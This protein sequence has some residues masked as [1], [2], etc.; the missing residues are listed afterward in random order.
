[1]QTIHLGSKGT[2][3]ATC[4]DASALSTF[5]PEHVTCISCL[6]STVSTVAKRI[7]R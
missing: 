3:S 6:C 4:G 2:F 1:M 5:Q 7:K